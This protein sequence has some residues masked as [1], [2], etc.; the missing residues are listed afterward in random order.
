MT[1]GGREV[2][3]GGALPI[4]Q[5]VCN[6][7]SF[8]PVK[9]STVNLLNLRSPGY[10]CSHRYTGNGVMEVHSNGLYLLHSGY[11]KVDVTYMCVHYTVRREIFIVTL[12]LWL[13][14]YYL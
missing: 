7:A 8:L 11:H 3:V 12:Y 1:S 5:L 6:K 13:D 14:L 4:N 10:V 2:D 9:S